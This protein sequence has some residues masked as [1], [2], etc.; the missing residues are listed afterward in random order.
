MKPQTPPYKVVCALDTETT[1]ITDPFGITSAFMVLYQIGELAEPVEQIDPARPFES[2]AVRMHRDLESTWDDLMDVMARH[3]GGCVPVCC[4]HNLG[5]DMHGFSEKL[6]EWQNGIGQVRVLAKSPQ[7][8]ITITLCIDKKPVFVFWDTLLFSGMGL[9]RMGAECDFEKAVGDWDYTRVRAPQT[10]LDADEERYAARDIGVIFSWLKTYLD[11][12]PFIAPDDLGKSAMTK[13]GAVRVKRRKMLEPVKGA[14]RKL[15]AGQ[16]WHRINDQEKLDDDDALFS[17]QACTRGGFVFCASKNAGR[18][19]ENVLAFDAKSQHPAQMVSH[20]YP[21]QFKK[22]S[23]KVLELDSRIVARVS[24][25]DVMRKWARPFPVAFCARFDFVN[26]RPKP[27]TV[28]SENGI[29]PL[30]YARV[31]RAKHRE[32]RDDEADAQREAE[33]YA[34]MAEGCKH[35]FGKIESAEVASLWLTELGFWEVCQAYVWDACIPVCGY[36][37]GRFVRPSDMAIL[38]V[39]EF[40]KRKDQIKGVRKSY[41]SRDIEAAAK[42]AETC[43]PHYLVER[44]EAGE[45]V[46]NDIETY[47]LAAKADLNSLFGIE[48]TNE[49]RR[50]MV[51]DERGIEYTGCEGAGNLPREPKAWYQFGQRIVGWSRIAQHIVLQGMHELGATVINGDTDSVKAA[52]ISVGEADAF[53]CKFGSCLDA[54]KHEVLKRVKATYPERFQELPRIGYYEHEATYQLF[55]SA[56]NKSYCVS[57]GRGNYELTLAG[58]P[59][60]KRSP[61]AHDSLEDFCADLDA[62]GWTFQ[63]VCGCVLGYDTTIDPAIT[64]LRQRFIPKFASRWVGTVNDWRGGSFEVNSPRAVGLA[65]MPKTIGG[66]SNEDNRQNMLRTKPNNPDLMTKP[67]ILTWQEEKACAIQL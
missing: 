19:F 12:E 53:L 25:A 46:S 44:I 58:V 5:F 11:R 56:W 60:S 51:I 20:M 36:E 16:M 33:G 21:V 30:A 31:H 2:C 28:Y 48:S 39:M 41:Y 67:H 32:G 62:Q 23:R 18:A 45:D 63:Q 8:P 55:Y 57:D 10:D 35:A 38:S 7:K 64:K 52:G 29:Y 61:G 54:A 65:P 22:A 24:A 42:Q 15:T 49:A 59:A 50:D 37:T 3:A 13:T 9:A 27:S 17:V 14:G 26:L 34:D 47:Y 43:L 4:I 66:L 6:L 40:Y 1:N